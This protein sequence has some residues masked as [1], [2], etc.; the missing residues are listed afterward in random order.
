MSST[1]YRSG[2]LEVRPAQ[3][4]L[5]ID[6]K[7]AVLGGRAFDLLVAMLERRDRVVSREQLFD[8]VWPGL[9][10]EENNLRQQV[11]TLRKLIG[12]DAVVTVPGRGYR[13]GLSIQ[14][15][16]PPSATPAVAP[17]SNLPLNRAALIGREEDLAA[18]QSLLGRTRLLTLSGSGGVG[19]TALALEAAHAVRNDYKDG[20]WL[21]ELAPIADPALVLR[22]VASVLVHEEPDRP[23]LQTVLDFLR[24]REV[25]IVLDN[26]EHLIEACA[27]WAAHVLRSSAGARILATSR[28]TLDVP[29]EMVWRVPSLAT[30]ETDAQPPEELMGY[31]ATQLFVRRATAS[32]PAFR[33]GPL[34]AAAVA[35]IC[36]RLDGIPLALELAAARVKAMR[37]EQVADR[38]H[39]RFA[40]LTCGSRTAL[41]RHQTLR[42]LVDWSHDLLTD[43]ERILLRR[44]AVFAGGWTLEAAESVCAGDG[45]AASEVLDALSHLV[46]KSLVLPDD[47]AAAP[48]YGMLET[49]RQ[50]G[51]EKLNAAGEAESV[52]TRHLDYFLELAESVRTAFYGPE[53]VTCNARIQAELDNLRVA[54]DWSEKPGR[55]RAG[56]LL[57]NSLHRYWYQ[58]LH[59]REIAERIERMASHEVEP[60]ARQERA[61]S[62]YV[63]AMLVTGFDPERAHRLGEECLRLSRA[64]DYDEGIAWSLMWLGYLESRRRDPAT[65]ARFE[66]SLRFGRRIGDPWRQ[67]ALMV[68]AMI[69]YAGYEALMGREAS[70]ET[71]VQEC[72]RHIAE[73]GNDILY[74]GHC[75]ALLGT[76]ATRRGEFKRASDLLSESLAL[77]RSVDSKFDVAGSLGQQ[78]FLA[79]QRGHPEQ[80]LALFRESLP[81]HSNYPTSPW[82]TKGLAHLLIAYAACERWHAAARLAGLLARE[83]GRSPATAPIELSGRVATAFSDAVRRTHSSL[84]EQ[85]FSDESAVGRS[86]AREEGIRF[87]LSA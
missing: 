14:D 36:R 66:E 72:E 40:F 73:I 41:Q 29:G 28:E 6:G 10:V 37:V 24:S 57:I 48:R 33:M 68:Q 76:L 60:G 39:D 3:R 52:R 87:A 34:N 38:L 30:P 26:C 53:T 55:T 78:G 54:L 2:R 9:V 17:P 16:A 13:L 45:L 51:L 59:W 43:A 85:A 47:K 77:Y 7:A 64:I 44:L 21:V 18:V 15:D 42:S 75:R 63:A 79:L 49:I 74:T 71:L 69:C 11:S 31:P 50:Y 46:E 1:R 58:N 62:H 22:A 84:G 86:M 23:L 81:L 32:N 8:I 12:A 83:G 82:I 67:A 27:V 56:L 5:L 25:L 35:Q 80:A 20:V 4:Q 65:S 70:V 19:K 61:R